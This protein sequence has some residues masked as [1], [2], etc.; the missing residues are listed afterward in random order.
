MAFEGLVRPFQLRDVFAAPQRLEA[1]SEV[2]AQVVKL[3]I[4]LT[5]GSGK[6]MNGSYSSTLTIYQKKHAVEKKQ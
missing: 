6:V 3:R 4:G 1:A 5:S 2:D